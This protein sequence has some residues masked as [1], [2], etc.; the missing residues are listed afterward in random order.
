MIK[1]EPAHCD[2][3]AVMLEEYASDWLRDA[4]MIHLERCTHPTALNAVGCTLCKCM[5]AWHACSGGKSARMLQV[6]TVHNCLSDWHLDLDSMLHVDTI[7]VL[8][9]ALL[10]GCIPF[11]NQL[12]AAATPGAGSG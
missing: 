1:D 12:L 7:F 8:W 5:S 10:A 3:F 9:R 11:A 2:G 4:A 6:A